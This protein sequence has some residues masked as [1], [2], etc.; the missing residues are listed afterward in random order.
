MFFL[1]GQSIKAP[2]YKE[3]WEGLKNL[4][5]HREFKP[6]SVAPRLEYKTLKECMETLEV[7]SAQGVLRKML[8][9]RRK[10]KPW[11]FK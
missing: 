7:L 2:N 10:M 11:E 9:H 6:F 3:L 4:D 1:I 5:G 8:E